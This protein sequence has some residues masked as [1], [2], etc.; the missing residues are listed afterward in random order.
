[1]LKFSVKEPLDID[2]E[3][4]HY[5]RYCGIFGFDYGFAAC[6]AAYRQ[7]FERVEERLKNEDGK[8]YTESYPRMY[9]DDN[10]D[11]L[12]VYIMV[13]SHPN[14]VETVKMMCNEHVILDVLEVRDEYAREVMSA[15]K[16][17]ASLLDV[18]PA[19]DIPRAAGIL[20]STKLYLFRITLKGFRLDHNGVYIPAILGMFLRSADW[21]TEYRPYAYRAITHGGTVQGL[22]DAT[23]GRRGGHSVFF[24]NIKESELRELFT[25]EILESLPRPP[26]SFGVPATA[27]LVSLRASKGESSDGETE[28]S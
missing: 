10:G 4:E 11:A 7:S 9:G 21:G 20:Y 14:I 6:F 26:Q 22:L 5:A 19:D 17:T 8:E 28:E 25:P 23:T 15:T 27:L 18:V 2:V 3:L 13:R 16:N 1:M 12:P 24:T